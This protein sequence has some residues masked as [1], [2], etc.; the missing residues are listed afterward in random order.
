MLK[1]VLLAGVIVVGSV[2]GAYPTD[3]GGGSGGSSN[4]WWVSIVCKIAPQAC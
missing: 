1:K 2:A 3:G 4:P